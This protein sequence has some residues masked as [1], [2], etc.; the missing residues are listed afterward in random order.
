MTSKMNGRMVAQKT[1]LCAQHIRAFSKKGSSRHQLICSRWLP[2]SA[3]RFVLDKTVVERMHQQLKC[4]R[5]F[6]AHGD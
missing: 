5:T 1:S 2:V 3:Y 6:S 4:T